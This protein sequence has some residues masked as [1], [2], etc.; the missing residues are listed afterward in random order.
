LL[1]FSNHVGESIQ[2]VV[3]EIEKKGYVILPCAIKL[4]EDEKGKVEVD[5]LC[6]GF[7]LIHVRYIILPCGFTKL[8]SI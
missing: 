6:L 7:Y 3:G 2:F 5:E 4:M 8:L 1:T